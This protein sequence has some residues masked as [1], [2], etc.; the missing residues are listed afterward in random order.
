MSFYTYKEIEEQIVANEFTTDALRDICRNEAAQD[1]NWRVA[2][3][4]RLAFL[5]LHSTSTANCHVSDPA[6]RQFLSSD[7]LKKIDVKRAVRR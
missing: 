1:V 2:A 5:Y 4:N 7:T 6:V 3:A